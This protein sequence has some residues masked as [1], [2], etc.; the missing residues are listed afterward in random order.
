MTDA[1][2]ASLPQAFEQ[3]GYGEGVADML[4]ETPTD[5]GPPITRR[6]STAAPRFANGS[7][8]ITSAQLSALKTFFNTTLLGGSLPFTFPAQ[9]D[10]G[11]P[12]VDWLVKFTR[13]GLPKWVPVGGDYWRASFGLTI[14]S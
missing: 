7:M 6:R 8:V 14:L 10:A 13:N 2:P 1:W 11:S 3:S 4:I 12:S 5:A 9:V